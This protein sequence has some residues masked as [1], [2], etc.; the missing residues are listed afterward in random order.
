MYWLFQEWVLG[1]N[2][3]MHYVRKTQLKI[4]A[5]TPPYIRPWVLPKM[6]VWILI[7][8]ILLK[9]L[10]VNLECKFWT[11]LPNEG[12][13]HHTHTP[14]MGFPL[15]L[16]TAL[17]RA[18]GCL[19]WHAGWA[20]EQPLCLGALSV[21]AAFGLCSVWDWCWQWKRRETC[22]FR[23]AVVSDA[24]REITEILNTHDKNKRLNISLSITGWVMTGQKIIIPNLLYA[25]EGTD[26]TYI[27][28]H[29]YLIYPYES[30]I[31]AMALLPPEHTSA[32]FLLLPWCSSNPREPLWGVR[33]PCSPVGHL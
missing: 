12:S 21:H 19:S 13:Q 29:M 8:A 4:R 10:K 22:L 26:K 23:H 15:P 6:R 28:I 32:K 1:H 3:I 14:E 18:A 9:P 31:P 5:V 20:L 25:L 17:P 7:T 11:L 33:L 2:R 27:R 30:S 24:P 16:H